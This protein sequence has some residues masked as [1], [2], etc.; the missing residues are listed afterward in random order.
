MMIIDYEHL[1]TWPGN[2]HFIRINIKG[3]KKKF[4]GVSKRDVKKKLTDWMIQNKLEFKYE[5]W[6]IKL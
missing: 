6:K 5:M 4:D 2:N 1:P 3:D